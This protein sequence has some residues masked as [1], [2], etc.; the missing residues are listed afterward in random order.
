LSSITTK[1]S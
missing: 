1:T